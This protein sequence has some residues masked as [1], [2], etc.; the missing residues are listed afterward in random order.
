MHHHA[1]E[2]SARS[3]DRDDDDDD[4]PAYRRPVTLPKL[5]FPSEGAFL[6][7][8]QCWRL[9]KRPGLERCGPDTRRD[10]SPILLSPSRKAVT[11][12]TRLQKEAQAVVKREDEGGDSC[13]AEEES[14]ESPRDLVTLFAT[15]E[16]AQ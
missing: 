9:R 6:A 3:R 8:I 12:G 4:C 14:G 5:E 2:R 16:A 13:M 10:Q 7:F 15:S 11:G 1:L